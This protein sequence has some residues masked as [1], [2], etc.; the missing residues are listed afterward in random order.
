MTIAHQ[1]RALAILAGTFLA[2]CSTAPRFNE[3]FGESVHANLSAQALNPA[4]A[5]NGDPVLGIDG[6]AA[7]AAQERYQRAF[8]E[9]ESGRDQPL[10]GGGSQQ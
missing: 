5:A 2:G 7:R 3:H 6:N 4:G 10:V 8:K 9:P 1:R